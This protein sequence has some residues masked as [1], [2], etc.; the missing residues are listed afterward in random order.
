MQT[1]QLLF[2]VVVFVLAGGVKGVTGMG[3]PTV[4]VSLLGLWLAPAQATALLLA[5]S[6]ATNVAQ[7]RGP[8]VAPGPAPVAWVGGSGGRDGLCA[9]PCSGGE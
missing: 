7:C 3:L 6:L 4:A 2:V 8:P 1:Q 9:R 5:P